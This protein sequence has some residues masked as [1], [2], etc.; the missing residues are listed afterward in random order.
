MFLDV[1]YR[2]GKLYRMGKELGTVN[3]NGYLVFHHEGVY[4]YVHR[5]VW[6]MHHNEWPKGRLDHKDEDKLNNSIEN[7]RDVSN[8]VNKHNVTAPNRDNKTSGVRGVHW[9]RAANKWVAQITIDGKIKHLG[10]FET[11][12]EAKF[13]YLKAKATGVFDKLEE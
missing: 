10:C 7:L 11:I 12:D 5:V 6:Y 9:S 3:S 13:T 8:S 2:D 1:E 4:H